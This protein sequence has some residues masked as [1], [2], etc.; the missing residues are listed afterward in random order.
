MPA[1]TAI[2]QAL[3]LLRNAERAVALTGAG[4]S[5]PS[6]IPD[7]RSP[8]SGLWENV[9][10]MEVASIYAFRHRPQAFYDWLRPL[11][12]LILAAEPNPAH[13][14][15]AELEAHGP[16]QAVIT[17]N[18]DL[19]HGRAGS[20]NVYEVHGQIREVVCLA[21]HYTLA[22]APLLE[23]FMTHGKLPHCPRCHHIMKPSAVLFGELLPRR[24]MKAAEHHS[25]T[26][27]VMLVIGTSLEVAP[28]GDLPELAKAHG[29][30][31]II[32]NQSP[33]HMDDAAEVVIRDDAAA[34]L[35]L[36]AAPFV[37][38]PSG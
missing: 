3:E 24:E 30:K 21:C 23:A 28:V 35:P 16:L 6:G 1:P 9:D 26:A 37:P 11:A 14:A 20:K 13:R 2:T 17:Q 33:T 32:I 10:V 27:D 22:A 5:T 15:L 25:R 12:A 38:Q 18:I 29:A 34:V 31:L 7:F 8:Q 4:I 19:L 36:L